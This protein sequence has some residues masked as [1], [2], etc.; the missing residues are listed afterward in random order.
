M[1]IDDS[2]AR[3]AAIV[4]SSDDAIVSKDLNG[5]VTSWNG[6]AERLFGYTADEMIGRS[7]TT[8]IPPDHKS[9]EDFVLSRVRAG[10]SVE[11]YETIRQRKDGSLVE[12]SLTVSPIRKADGTII[13][14]SKIARDIS[15]RRH[16]E[17][18]A[19]RLA[20]IVESSADA[21]IG[22]D[23][24]GII[25]TWNR[26]AERMFGFT[27]AE[28]VGKPLT[29]IVPDNRVDEEKSVLDRVRR[30]EGISGLE[31][32]RR[33][34]AGEQIDVSLT[35][36]PIR[37]RSGEIIGASTIAR[38]ISEQKRLRRE[39]EDASRAKDEFLATLSHELRTPLN[40]VLGY[41]QMMQRGA[42][43]PQDVGKA[44]ETIS[45]NAEALTSLVNDVLDT[46]RIV[47]GKIRLNMEKC[48]LAVI[49]DEAVAGVEPAVEAKG[50]HLS[51][52][53]ARNLL[54]YGDRDR[55]KQ[56]LWN[57]LSN[58]VK[59]TPPGGEMTVSASSESSAVR[60]AVTDSG[61]GI[62][63]ES[64]PL[65]FQRFWQADST[66][67]RGQGGL[68]LGLALVRHFVELHGGHVSAHSEGPG[69][70]ARFEVVLPAAAIVT[71]SRPQPSH[72]A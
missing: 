56:V 69:R 66:H 23:L 58:A 46:S 26:G 43:Q 9:E 22:K 29:I 24:G 28:I 55:L 15:D 10:L 6:A 35:V 68:G 59:F 7:I 19:L 61:V 11:H 44:I 12:I 45:R 52:S 71:A 62:P 1:T 3:L 13:G 37:T 32:V 27:A 54:V 33:T 31:T 70:G 38:D 8:I 60:V 34:K 21:I 5:I 47:T 51:T 17:R 39:A 36:S 41:A 16:M 49:A 65:I 14:A 42:I 4:A 67:T 63:P 25:Q 48:D 2:A 50:I 18:E 20:A 57:L 30:G 53:I 40:T 72:V 64:L